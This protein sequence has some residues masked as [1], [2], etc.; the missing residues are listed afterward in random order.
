MTMD[1]LVL[2]AG[3]GTRLQ[4]LGQELPKPLLYLPGGTLLDY[5]LALL[6]EIP[7]DRTLVV[8][9]HQW[10]QIREQVAGRPPVQLVQQSAPFTLVGALISAA[11]YISQPTLVLHGDNYFADNPASYLND[12]PA[13][14]FLHDRT[15]THNSAA[16]W[17]KAGAYRLEPDA[18]DLI[19]AHADG[20]SLQEIIHVLTDS[21]LPVG[22][23]P[24]PF[25]RK[26]INTRNDLLLT[27]RYLLGAWK[28]AFHPPGAE[29][30]HNYMAEG[31]EVTRPAWIHPTADVA[32]S[33]IGP[34]VTIGAGAQVHDTRIEEA[35]VFPE[36]RIQGCE[37][38]N[39]L[40]VGDIIYTT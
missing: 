21:D 35:V 38:V 6:E 10:Q 13:N 33:H 9:A 22:G 23:Q 5:Q 40:V 32:G 31:C 20:D 24:V 25:W 8:V 26:N 7:V 11:P 3:R 37:I 18:F 16:S 27:Q 30:G 28:Q 14:V 1:A 39:A 2:A 19:T 29:S 12:G 15:E 17:G 36:S 4:E 34:N